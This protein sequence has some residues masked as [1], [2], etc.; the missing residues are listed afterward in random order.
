VTAEDFIAVAATLRA[1]LAA[2]GAE[3]AMLVLDR[4][5]DAPPVLLDVDAGAAIAVV[6]EREDA[7]DWEAVGRAAP[8]PLPHV[9]PLGRPEVDAETAELRAPMGV[10]S[11]R[12]GAASICARRAQ[13]GRAS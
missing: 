7:L 11:R 8:D 13:A 3:R 9:H 5:C 1:F 2:G 4:G 12:A 6:R 10:V